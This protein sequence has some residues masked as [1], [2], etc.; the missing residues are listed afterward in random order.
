MVFLKESFEKVD[1]EKKISTRQIPQKA[2][3]VRNFQMEMRYTVEISF[4]IGPVFFKRIYSTYI[5]EK[6]RYKPAQ[7]YGI[8]AFALPSILASLLAFT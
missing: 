2:Q 3:I 6:N 5:H 1:F 4:T 7:F 8:R